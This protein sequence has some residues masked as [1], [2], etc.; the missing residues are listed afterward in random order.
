[1]ANDKAGQPDAPATPPTG[2]GGREP[3]VDGAVVSS[4][5]EAMARDRE[6]AAQMFGTG[7]GGGTGGTPRQPASGSPGDPAGSESA[8]PPR[9]DFPADG[10]SKKTD[11]Q[12]AVTDTAERREAEEVARVLMQRDGWSGERMDRIIGDMSIEELR[13]QSN[14]IRQ[15]QAD[16]DRMGNEVHNQ[17]SN[18]TRTEDVPLED[19][20]FADLTQSQ[21]IIVQRAIDGGDEELA[22]AYLDEY[23]SGPN[24]RASSQP[25]AIN[26][27]A[28][29]DQFRET[30]DLL[31]H[32][33]PDLAKDEERVEVVR[34]AE[35]LAQAGV[36]SDQPGMSLDRAFMH[37]ARVIY[38]EA[39]PETHARRM[40]AVER[41]Q[42]QRD[43]QPEPGDVR[44]NG[45]T[46]E[47]EKDRD[48]EA[49]RRL[50]R[51][52]SPK[53][54]ARSLPDVHR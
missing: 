29:A 52:E 13:D 15:R 20:D 30:F 28:V 38:G 19:D 24:R 35:R 54:I 47:S 23:R 43:G 53:D 36:F 50:A 49:F 41:N 46:F 17:R 6:I 4:E 5:D 32:S 9:G 25:D 26:H 37:A 44:S 51:G 33:Y 7:A 11:D 48:R 10:A 39:N 21:R 27:G 8:A 14:K 34:C 12:Q 42:Q 22:R 16:Q 3:R 45:Q 2:Q 1:M 31:T 40:L 18:A